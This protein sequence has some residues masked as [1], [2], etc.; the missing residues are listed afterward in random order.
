MEV[1][2]LIMRKSSGEGWSV[3]NFY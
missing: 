2:R 1:S 3:V